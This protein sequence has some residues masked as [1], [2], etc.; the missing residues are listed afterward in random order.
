[1]RYFGP[2]GFGLLTVA[3]TALPASAQDKAALPPTTACPAAVA[4]IATCYS[5][6]HESGAYLL[7]AMP[8]NWNGNLIVFAH[9]GPAV[10]PPT[11]TTSQSDLTRYA[12]LVK[13]GYGWV[14]SSYRREG[15][16]VRMA[17]ED[18]DH[19]RRFFIERIGKPK[20]TIMHGQ[21]Y[22]G[23]VS[24]KVLE[25]YG[26]S[27]DGSLNYD[28][29]FLNSGL[30]IGAA[31]GHEF[32]ADLRAVYQYY[33]KNLPRPDEAQYPL[34]M[35]LPAESKMTLKSLEALVDECTGI[36]KPAN[37]RTDLQKQN[38]ANILGVMRIPQR[39]FVRHLQAATF[40]FREIVERTTQGRN[41]FSN[42]G[43]QYNG[44]TDDVAL[45]R[46][47]ARFAA[48]PVAIANLKADG[49]PTGAL[50]VPVLSIH[51][52]ND[53]RVAV[54]VQSV[55]R[56]VVTAAGNGERLVQIFT[57][58][59][60]HSGQSASEVSAAYEALMQWIDKGIKPTPQAIAARCGELGTTVEG[61]CRYHP[62]F[63]PK[64]YNTRY[65]R[66]A[67]QVPVR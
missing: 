52:I 40:L 38:L 14:A 26:K 6:K 7:A 16:G 28:G 2:A 11:A 18:S 39:E 13:S 8:K 62:E 48:D 59:N 29:A 61:P 25:L 23:L 63:T 10:V 12:Y 32:R 19:A 67:A 4:E 46:D 21:S 54:E 43:V 20:R 22:G 34:W 65:A 9:G 24:T 45:N 5:A 50:P 36:A 3:M 64:S 15:Y 51:S 35:G 57:D 53:P 30:V 27:A 56:D 44:S 42:I 66:G 17:A 58:E 55:Y 49:S 37:A 31:L 47:V 41:A 1:M 60:E 33:C